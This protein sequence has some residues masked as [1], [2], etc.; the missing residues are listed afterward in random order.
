M[1]YIQTMEEHSAVKSRKII[2]RGDQETQTPHVLSN[3]GS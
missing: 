1:W 2:L 3:I